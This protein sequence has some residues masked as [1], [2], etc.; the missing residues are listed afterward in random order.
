[1]S[2]GGAGEG[3]ERAAIVTKFQALSSHTFCGGDSPPD[4]AIPT[5]I[6]NN[7]SFA[8]LLFHTNRRTTGKKKIKI[9][10]W[11]VRYDLWPTQH[12]VKH[13]A[14]NEFLILTFQKINLNKILLKT[15]SNSCVKDLTETTLG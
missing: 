5:S 6:V 11:R 4:V 14:F 1:M 15:D 2:D 7:L 13:S 9:N 3:A 8:S 10:F 12:A